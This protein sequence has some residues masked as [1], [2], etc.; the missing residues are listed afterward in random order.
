M[1]RSMSNKSLFLNAT[2]QAS[3]RKVGGAQ[4]VVAPQYP[5][6]WT[7]DKR[8]YPN[9]MGLVAE[10]MQDGEPVGDHNEWLLAAFCGNE[11]RGLA[12]T[13]AGRLMMNVYG[14][15]GEKITFLV[16]HRESGE[17][18]SISES[19]EFGAG[20]L[21]SVR[22]PRQLNMGMVTGIVSLDNERLSD[23]DDVYDLQ[24]RKVDAGQ[25]QKGVYIV[26]DSKNGETQKVVRK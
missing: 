9:V 13:V 15:G 16:M 22:Q 8:R 18:L 14:Q 5:D 25:S 20:L 6:N 24:G 4:S 7:V 12:Q 1:F 26:T 19:E 3:S 23:N 10:L 21:G 2:A 17:I 11:C